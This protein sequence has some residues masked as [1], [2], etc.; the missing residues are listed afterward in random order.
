MQFFELIIV[1]PTRVIENRTVSYVRCPGLDG[2]FGIM[3]DHA[4]AI[5]AL[6]VGPV[7]IIGSDGEK[8][9]ATSGGYAEIKENR[10]LLLVESAEFQEEID[11]ERARKA[12][13]RAEERLHQKTA[14]RIRAKSSLSRAINRLRIVQ[15]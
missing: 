15:Q 11:V 12:R 10:V 3:K 14:D 2:S 6:E 1:T 5:F 9:L 4:E 13:E 7:K 8:W